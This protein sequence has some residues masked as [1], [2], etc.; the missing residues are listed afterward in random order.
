MNSGPDP[1]ANLEALSGLLRGIRGPE[2]GLVV[3][4]ENAL[5]L[6]STEDY[7]A[8]AEELGQG[9]VQVELAGLA[10]RHSVWLW[11]G[12][13]PVRSEDGRLGAT[14]LVFD[15]SGRLRAH[16]RKLHLFDVEV[17]G[18]RDGRSHRYRESDAFAPGDREVVVETPLGR[19]GA[20]ICYDLRF[21]GLFTRL[22]SLGAEMLVVPAAF[23]RATGEAHWELLLR[24]RAVETQCF[25]L[26]PA[27]GGKHPDGRETWGHSMAVDPWGRVLG[28]LDREPG[29]LT[30]ELDR[31]EIGRVRSAMPLSEHARH[32][33][34]GLRR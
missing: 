2:V 32:A 8:A 26:A 24:A 34:P 7:R 21:P 6:G 31:A 23:T 4:P 25:V 15:D 19:V 22:R 20:T 10:R 3:T 13:F 9:P 14:S 11:V 5:V 12:S 17:A 18:D 30:V 1:G 27:Q 16:Y 28:S 33:P 29:I